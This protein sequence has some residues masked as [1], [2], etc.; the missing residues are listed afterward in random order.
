M[1]MS[2][3]VWFIQLIQFYTTEYDAM[4]Q[5]FSHQIVIKLL[6]GQIDF[7]SFLAR[8]RLKFSGLRSNQY[9]ANCSINPFLLLLSLSSH[10]AVH[11]CY[12]TVDNWFSK[13]MTLGAYHWFFPFV[14]LQDPIKFWHLVLIS[15]YLKWIIL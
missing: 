8:S 4:S 15:D 1:H 2:L 10:R 14:L 6:F 5:S 3:C 13:V 7:C 12:L 9:C 11:C